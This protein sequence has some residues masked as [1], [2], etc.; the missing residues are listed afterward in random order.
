MTAFGWSHLASRTN[1]CGL[2]CVGLSTTTATT[3]TKTSEVEKFKDVGHEGWCN[4]FKVLT[5]Y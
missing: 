2:A 1:V 5:W 3:T 4:A